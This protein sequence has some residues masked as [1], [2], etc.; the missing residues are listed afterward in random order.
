M[1]P[2]KRHTRSAKRRI[3]G[4]ALSAA[5]RVANKGA[6]RYEGDRDRNRLGGFVKKEG[7]P[8]DAVP[9]PMIPREKEVAHRNVQ[10]MRR[11]ESQKDER[12][13]RQQKPAAIAKRHGS[14]HKGKK[15]RIGSMTRSVSGEPCES[16][17]KNA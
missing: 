3:D 9:G 16:G 5:K 2:F 11:K 13:E 7:K 4:K 14:R 17:V 1:T 15:K 12:P 6:E 10:G 8:L